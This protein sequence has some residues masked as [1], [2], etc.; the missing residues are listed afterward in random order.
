MNQKIEELLKNEME[1]YI[2]PFFWQHG[3]PEAVLREYM[4]VIYDA[5]IRAV[6]VE[7]RPHPDFAGDGWWRDMNII[8]DEA[9]KRDMK[10]WFLDDSHFPTG[11]CN[12][13]MEEKPTACRRWFLTYKVLGE[14]TEGET[15]KWV[16]QEYKAVPPF[17]PSW[18]ENYFHMSFETFPDDKWIGAVAVKKG[19]SSENDLIPIMEMEQTLLFTAPEGEWKIYSLM[20]TRNR[21]PHRNYMNMLDYEACHTVIEAVYEP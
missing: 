19:G 20:L 15:Q 16:A 1:N 3:E 7:S 4:K 9:R 5:N 6:C 18:I 10:V 2:F 8:L 17:E 11:Y 13:K 14:M 12:G 21:G